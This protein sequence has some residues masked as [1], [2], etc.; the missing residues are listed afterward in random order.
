MNINNWLFLSEY[1]RSTGIKKK[2]VKKMVS[3]IVKWFDTRK[4]YGFIQETDSDGNILEIDEPLDEENE[5]EDENTNTNDIF[6]HF[7]SIQVEGFKTLYKGDKVTFDLEEG[8]KGR[9]AKNVVIVERAPRPK[10][11]RKRRRPM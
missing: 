10:R 2:L 5:N 11:R 3:G 7:S 4:G 9:E 1:P 6:V 8:E